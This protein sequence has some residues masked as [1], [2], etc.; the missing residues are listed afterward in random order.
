WRSFWGGIITNL[1]MEIV[2]SAGA[3]YHGASVEWE[4]ATPLRRP[5]TGWRDGRRVALR[6]PRASRGSA[7]LQFGH[8]RPA[9][10]GRFDVDNVRRGCDRVGHPRH[11]RLEVRRVHVRLASGAV[12]EG[13]EQH[14]LVGPFGA[15]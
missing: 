4:C 8:G 14:K 10:A 1:S 7:R 9:V 13:F 12:P 2:L 15:S 3:C 11:S 6:L 5:L